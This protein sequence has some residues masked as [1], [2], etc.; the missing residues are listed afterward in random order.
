VPPAAQ[1]DPVELL[2]AKGLRPTRQRVEVLAELAKERDDATA[3]EL[4]ARL[5]DSGSSTIGL[6]TVY[7]TL[8]RLRDEGIIDAL[9]HHDAEQCYRLCTD[10]HHHHLLC[11]KC[12]R[13][14]EVDEC[15]LGAWVDNVAAQHGFV[16]EHHSVE[17]SGLCGNCRA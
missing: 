3:Q 11:V 16:A 2:R 9:S 4:W 1:T 13:V 6:A 8:A 15:S 14:V 7:R 5:R 17:I 10:A 12:H